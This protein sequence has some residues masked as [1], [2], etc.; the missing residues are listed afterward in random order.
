MNKRE[1]ER[2]Y[3]RLLKEFRAAKT[4]ESKAA[5]AL[6]Q[7]AEKTCPAKVGDE[8][9]YVTGEPSKDFSGIITQ[10]RASFSN[11]RGARGYFIKAKRR[12]LRPTKNG[13]QWAHEEVFVQ[14]QFIKVTRGTISTK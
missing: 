13:R 9:N 11:R 3:R 5:E 4:A 1:T 12:L 6:Q 10:V 7:F 14:P 2:T 8:F